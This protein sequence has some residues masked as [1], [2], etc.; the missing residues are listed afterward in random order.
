MS[1]VSLDWKNIKCLK[2]LKCYSNHNFRN[3]LSFENI[4]EQD[5]NIGEYM[6]IICPQYDEDQMN[7]MMFEVYNVTKEVFDSCGKINEG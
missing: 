3:R 7:I 2:L 4:F 6:D 1:S 5:V